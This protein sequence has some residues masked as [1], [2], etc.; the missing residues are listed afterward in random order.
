MD[1]LPSLTLRILPGRYAVAQ[2]ESWPHWLPAQGLVSVTRTANEFSVVCE[3]SCVPAGV[4]AEPGW[5]VLEFEGPFPFHLTGI[6]HSVLHPLAQAKIG[7]FAV[8]TYDTDYVLVKATD[9]ER[10]RAALTQAGHRLRSK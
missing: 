5:S 8:S 9:F 2:P 1:P 3:Q 4:K 7:V 6:L 10:A